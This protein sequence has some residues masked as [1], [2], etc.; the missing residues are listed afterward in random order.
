[1]NERIM[2]GHMHVYTPSGTVRKLGKL[3]SLAFTFRQ[4]AHTLLQPRAER[5]QRKIVFHVRLSSFA[6]I[7]M[8]TYTEKRERL[9]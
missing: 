3:F 4:T 6:C 2:H 7:N 1:M 8:F 5:P 9:D